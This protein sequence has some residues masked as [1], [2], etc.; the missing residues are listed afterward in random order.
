MFNN[1][2]TAIPITGIIGTVCGD[3]IGLPYE[4]R[5]S[6]TKN[7]NFE[8]KFNDF[9]D[10]TIL[11]VAIA[12]WLMGQR[13]EQSLRQHLIDY[14]LRFRHKNVWGWGFQKWFESGGTIDRQGVTSNGAAMRVSAIGYASDNVDE[15]MRL[16][17]L[18][19]RVSHNSEEAAHGAQAVAA[20][21]CL[22]RT[23]TTKQHIARFIENTFHYNLNRTVEEI[24]PTYQFE[25]SCAR[26]VPES[27]ICWL[28]STTYEQAV[29]N[30]V[31]L[32]GDA[33]TMA[34]IAGGIAA[35]TPG[36]EVPADWAEACFNLLPEDFQR[37]ILEFR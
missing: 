31:S 3:V 15:V 11:T 1:P 28:Q 26:C 33:D 9:S 24:R 7:F 4:L 5:D 8:V 17:E 22:T 19:A 2:S 30:A 29:R 21:V 10:D 18:S 6:R 13:T 12:H 25:I 16:A 23:G 20:A 34:A 35:A 14:A 36:M 27:I 37:T 32:G